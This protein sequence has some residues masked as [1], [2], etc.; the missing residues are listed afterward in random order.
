MAVHTASEGQ[1]NMHKNTI[2]IT[3]ALL[4]TCSMIELPSKEQ[5]NCKK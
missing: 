3:I 1:V 5:A 2:Y 4:Y